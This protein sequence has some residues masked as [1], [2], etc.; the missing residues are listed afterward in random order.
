[1]CNWNVDYLP[2][3][4]FFCVECLKEIQYYTCNHW[5]LVQTFSYT[6]SIMHYTSAA[7]STHWWQQNSTLD[8]VLGD[9]LYCHRMFM[10]YWVYTPWRFHESWSVPTGPQRH[11]ELQ[12]TLY[13]LYTQL[14]LGIM[15]PHGD[16]S[17]HVQVRVYY[18]W[19]K[20]IHSCLSLTV[21]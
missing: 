15:I 10:L 20:Y 16:N 14:H 9:H 2:L 4:L 1:M 7:R 17:V 3:E 6:Q 13:K 8:M 5:W 12:A 21:H 19:Y 11:G 18:S